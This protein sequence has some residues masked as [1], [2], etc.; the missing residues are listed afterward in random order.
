M[1]N[2]ITALDTNTLENLG[3]VQPAEEENETTINE[4]VTPTGEEG[5]TPTPPDEDTESS[6]PLSEIE[7]EGIGKV[8]VDEIREWQ[9]GNMRQSDYT[10]KTQE[11][12]KQREEANDAL[13]VFNYLRSNPHLIQQ[14][15]AMDENGQVNQ[16]VLNKST[17]ENGMMQQ[18]W[19]N[20]KSMEI[21][22]K[23]AELKN[24]YGDFDEVNL[25]NTAKDLRT[26]NLEFVLKGMNY[27][28]KQID[29]AAL[30]EKAK[31]ELK[32]ELERNKGVVRTIATS[33]SSKP[34]VEKVSQLSEQE[35]RV[36]EGMGMSKEEYAKWKGK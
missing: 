33:P 1:E 36:A 31:A 25:L 28:H 12:A 26:D 15:Q 27:E 3:I 23:L 35:I 17:P 7:I 20:Q 19:Y 34:I 11:L 24:K 32:A 21:D 30:M 8:K 29:E 13:E 2:N 16:E 18:L 4:P 9:K 14:L 5:G 6:T 10:R 22:Y